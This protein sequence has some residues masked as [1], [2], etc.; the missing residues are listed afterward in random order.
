MTS[1]ADSGDILITGAVD[2]GGK[3]IAGVNDTGDT[4]LDTFLACLSL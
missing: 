4:T 2:T 3:S 1:V